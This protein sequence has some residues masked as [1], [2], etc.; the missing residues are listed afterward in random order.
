MCVLFELRILCILGHHSHFTINERSNDKTDI[1]FKLS[2]VENLRRSI[3]GKII[4]FTYMVLST[5]L[6]MTL[7]I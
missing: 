5:L 4:L 7:F 1:T 3:K 2:T 6:F